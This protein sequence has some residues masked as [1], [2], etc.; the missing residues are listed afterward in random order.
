MDE[1]DPSIRVDGT[2]LSI[3][4][5]GASGDLARKKIFPALFALH[6]QGYLPGRFQ[7]LGFARTPLS[8]EQF[9]TRIAEHLTCR[10]TPGESCADQTASFLSR[11]RYVAGQY[12]SRESF[13]DLYSEMRAQEGSGNANRVFY[14]A[15]PPSLFLDVAR[16]IAGAGLVSCDAGAGWSRA[17]I[18]KPFG[19]DR[20]SSD[21]LVESMAQIFEED[22]IYRIDHY[23]GKEV[24]QNLLVLRFANLVFEP[25]WNRR[26]IDNVQ[27]CWKEDVGV[28]DRGGYF[29]RY[30]IVRDVVQNHLLQIVALVAMEPPIDLSPKTV[31]DEKVRV[32]SSMSPVQLDD[33]V[34]GQYEG[35]A[36]DGVRRPG[37]L[38]EAHVA[39]GSRTPT[40]AACVLH[41]HNPRWEGVAFFVRAGKGLDARMTE[42]CIRF[43]P[44]PGNVFC[45][46]RGCPQ[47]NELVIRVQPDEAIS[48]RITNKIPGIEIALGETDLDLRYGA[49][50]E[51]QIPEAYECLLLDVMKGDKS[52]FIRADELAAAWDVF[53]PTL[54]A[55]DARAVRPTSYPFGSEGPHAARDLAQRYG[56]TW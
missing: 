14:M 17:V 8:C 9:R 6:C 4:V 20:R 41:V 7:I 44:V 22:Q 25:I 49:K 29:D 54:H 12:D 35:A 48:L 56:V 13:L 50:F 39:E 40:Y 11:C 51:T 2:P 24:I 43:R 19:Y 55:I 46:A 27:I 42:I 53:T 47:S 28:G 32:L 1:G 30:G 37:Y 3:V 36:I 34:L 16:A 45:A 5:I 18:E 23:L 31:R 38:E 21:E 52:L 10:Y 33:L 26:C 15:I